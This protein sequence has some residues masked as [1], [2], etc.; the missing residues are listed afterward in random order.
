MNIHFANRTGQAALLPSRIKKRF[1]ASASPAADA[2][3]PAVAANK[4][5]LFAFPLDLNRKYTMQS[6]CRKVFS[7]FSTFSFPSGPVNFSRKIYSTKKGD[8]C[9]GNRSGFSP[10]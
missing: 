10:H 1:I 6:H 9:T 3:P 7:L 8:L 5:I 4:G 2:P